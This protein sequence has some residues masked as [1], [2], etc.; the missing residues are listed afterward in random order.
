MLYCYLL[1][2]INVLKRKRKK[3][4]AWTVYKCLSSDSPFF[5]HQLICSIYKY[6]DPQ[7]IHRVSV[8]ICFAACFIVYMET[9]LDWIWLNFCCKY[10]LLVFLQLIFFKFKIPIIYH[11]VLCLSS[12][13]GESLFLQLWAYSSVNYNVSC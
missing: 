3:E 7:R 13:I 6:L 2:F 8:C 11:L 10:M 5:I 12:N 4:A 1:L 9:I